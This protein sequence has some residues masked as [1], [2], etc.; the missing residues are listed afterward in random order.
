M[1]IC[2]KIM[3]DKEFERDQK[4]A[5]DRAHTITTSNKELMERFD[6]SILNQLNLTI[7]EGPILDVGCGGTSCFLLGY[8]LS[9]VTMIG[10]D[11][12]DYQLNDMA[13][14]IEKVC[15]TTEKFLPYFMDIVEYELPDEYAP[16]SLIVLSNILHFHELQ[17]CGIL[18]NE[19]TERTK[20]GSLIYISVHS[21]KHPFAFGDIKGSPF[22]HFFSKE[23]IRWLFNESQYEEV[24]VE[25]EDEPDTIENQESRIEAVGKL[26]LEKYDDFQRRGDT[27]KKDIIHKKVVAVFRRK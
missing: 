2:Y 17:D 15:G 21:D 18:I 10:I 1:I 26:L 13:D 12:E 16:Y 4:I 6:A 24:Y 8:S 19:V 7:N 3:D 22:K 11:K 20:S 5:S 27:P 25:L 9:G 14:R 23:D